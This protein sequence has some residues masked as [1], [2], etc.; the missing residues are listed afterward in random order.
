MSLISDN[1]CSSESAGPAARVVLS[2]CGA[3]T[4]LYYGPSLAR[5]Q[6]KG[7]LDVV[8]L[9]D[10]D[11]GH[12]M[13]LRD[14]FPGAAVV[15][16]FN[17][18]LGVGADVLIIAS[19]PRF[20]ADQAVAG[21]RSGLHVF[22]EKPLATSIEDADRI[23]ATAE[24]TGLSA[25]VGLVRRQFPATAA[26]RKFLIRA[27]SA[28]SFSEMLRGWA[29]RLARRVTSIL[30]TRVVRRRRSSGYRNALS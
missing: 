1:A 22:C 20:H 28:N 5:L 8:G 4:Q 13:R 12:A 23:L 18:L 3:V 16:D 9:F 11:R 30:R 19:P 2:G 29:V 26:S 24:A 7:F 14:T 21:L 6:A 17:E 27:L 25:A 10:P 15:S